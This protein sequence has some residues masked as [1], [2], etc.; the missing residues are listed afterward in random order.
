MRKIILLLVIFTIVLA[1]NSQSLDPSFAGKGYQSFGFLTG[2]FYYENGGQV[3]RKPDGSFF[4]LYQVNGYAVV[5][6]YSASGDRDASYG[7]AG[8]SQSTDITEAKAALQSDGKIV[9]AGSVF[10]PVTRRSD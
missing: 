3:L 5:S 2:N 7:N 8:Y 6:H 9:I 4:V 10:D 1:V